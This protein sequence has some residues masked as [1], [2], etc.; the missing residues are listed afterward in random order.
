[1][2]K[3]TL[4]LAELIEKQK[5]DHE[6]LR[7]EYQQKLA[8]E[9]KARKE[10]IEGEEKKYMQAKMNS[11]DSI[12]TTA[13]F[14]AL[15]SMQDSDSEDVSGCFG[16]SSSPKSSKT[17]MSPTRRKQALLDPIRRWNSFHSRDKRSSASVARSFEQFRRDYGKKMVTCDVDIPV[18]TSITASGLMGALPRVVAL[19]NESLPQENVVSD[20]SSKLAKTPSKDTLSVER[21]YHEKM[22]T[23]SHG[24]VSETLEGK[25][26]DSGMKLMQQIRRERLS[27]EKEEQN[28]QWHWSDRE[29]DIVQ[30]DDKCKEIAASSPENVGKLSKPKVKEK[31]LKEKGETIKFR[32]WSDKD[33]NE[34]LLDDEKIKNENLKKLIR[35]RTKEKL[36]VEREATEKT[37][38]W[39]DKQ[40]ED[41]KV[42]VEID[43]NS[44]Y[45]VG[46][47]SLDVDDDDGDQTW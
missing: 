24:D 31:V 26:W 39:S 7:A 14:L 13:A 37:R 6:R 27:T 4:Q 12:T 10:K 17:P 2:H 5:L 29:D 35:R 25:R 21:G 43:D 44:T 32:R 38:K 19:R 34:S 47:T 28:K 45:V 36:M 3:H 11:C 30:I 20:P 16:K 33:E 9:E 8:K 23:L 1:M 22:R 41:E 46:L 15:K 42:K 18:N 40:E